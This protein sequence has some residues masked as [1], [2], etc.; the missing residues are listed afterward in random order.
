[1]SRTA[2]KSD[3]KLWQQV[4]DEIT[5][6]NKGDD[7][8]QWS[9]RKAQLAVQEYKNRGGGYEDDGADRDETS[10]RQW[11][12]NDNAPG[13][14]EDGG[15]EPTKGDLYDEAKRRDISGRSSMDKDELKSAID[16]DKSGS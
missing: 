9:A 6:G 3:P 12:Q 1:M 13:K 16:D 2:E 7:P 10:L 14:S 11:T 4:K 8:G 15:S 5:A